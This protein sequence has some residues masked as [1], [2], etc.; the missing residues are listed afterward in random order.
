[1]KERTRFVERH[2]EAYGITLDIYAKLLHLGSRPVIDRTGLTG[3][4]NI[5]LE[6]PTDMPASPDGGASDP[7]G[8][9]AIT[10]MREQLGLQLASGKGPREFLVIDRVERPSGN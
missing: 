5:H 1:M 9:S 10:A 7:P 4:F 8:T 6:L 2:R 3:A